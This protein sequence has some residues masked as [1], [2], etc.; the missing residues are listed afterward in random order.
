[1]E[2]LFDYKEKYLKY[3]FKYLELQSHLEGGAFLT[4]GIK[5]GF[6]VA[7]GKYDEEINEINHILNKTVYLLDGNIIESYGYNPNENLQ[8]AQMLYTNTD[9]LLAKSDHTQDDTL[10][11]DTTPVQDIN[12]QNFQ[13][14]RQ[15]D[16]NN[17]PNVKKFLHAVKQRIK[18][19]KNKASDN[20]QGDLIKSAYKSGVK[21]LERILDIHYMCK[22]LT[23]IFTYTIKEC[24]TNIYADQQKNRLQFG[25]PQGQGQFG[26]P[27][28]Q[29]QFGQPQGQSR[30]MPFKGGDLTQAEYK[31]KY[32]KYKAKYYQ[33]VEQN[34]AFLKGL[35]DKAKSLG[36][37]AVAG[38][39]TVGTSAVSGLKSVASSAAST[40][41]SFT[42]DGKAEE[43]SK[44]LQG[45]ADFSTIKLNANE[46]TI[47]DLLTQMKKTNNEEL[48]KIKNKNQKITKLEGLLTSCKTKSSSEV[49]DY[50]KCFQAP[51]TTAPLS[52]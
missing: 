47:K 30:F 17:L 36:S 23:S 37:S 40:A 50:A 21:S 45:D 29:G 14:N 26:Q 9:L 20:N 49:Y 34:G 39:K 18:V 46:K 6:K 38:L 25:Q 42:Q 33:L 2:E 4:R 52:L 27:Q 51:A 19:Y 13:I 11:D 1:M 12:F 3:K 31:Q 5:K 32:Y 8:G 7:T 15:Q 28:G 10:Q 24:F 48:E 41:K 35:A 43:V 44:I 16:L 22:G